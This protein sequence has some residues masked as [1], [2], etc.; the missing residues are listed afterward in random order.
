MAFMGRNIG[1]GRARLA[2]AGIIAIFGRMS[3][4]PQTRRFPGRRRVPRP[5]L[6]A[7]AIALVLL[8]YIAPAV[9]RRLTDLMWYEEVGLGHV[10]W[11]KI[12]AQWTLGLSIGVV[13]LLLFVVN[14]RWALVTWV[15]GMVS[16]D[17]SDPAHAVQAF[18]GA[19]IAPL[20]RWIVPLVLAA[21][22]GFGAATEWMTV[23]QFWY[24]TPFGVTD[25]IFQRDIGYYV[26]TVPMI[27]A[28]LT[29]LRA[30]AILSLVVIA[31]PL[32]LGLG[33]VGWVYRSRRITPRASRHLAALVATVLVLSGLSTLFVSVPDALQASHAV[34]QGATYTDIHIRIPMLRLLGIVTLVGALWVIYDAWRGRFVRGA[35]WVLGAWLTMTVV[36]IGVVPLTYQR[37]VVQANEL[38]RE[39]P[40]LSHYIA[41]TRRAWGI[42]S[43]DHRELRPPVAPLTW[44]DIQANRST[45][46]NI[47]L[48]DQAELLETY[49]QLQSIRTYYDFVGIDDDRY[50]IAGQPRQLLLSVRELNANALP[51]R[52][53]INDHLTYTHG[54]GLTLSPANAVTAEGLPELW[55]QDL[56]PRTNTSIQ[57]SRPQVYFGELTSDFAIAPSRQHEFDYPAGSG[58]SA[59]YSQ[60]AGKAG[61][62]ARSIVTRLLFALRFGSINILL[63]DDFTP[64]TRL[65]INRD[66]RRRS[67]LALPFLRFDGDPY[68]VVAADGTLKWILDAYTTTTRY[69][70]SQ[71]ARDGTNYMRNSVKVVID[72]Y[73]GTITPYIADPGDPMIRTL[74]RIYPNVLRPIDEMP[75]DL[76]AHVRY[77]YDLFRMQ[78]AMYA[79]FHMTDPATFYHREDQWQVPVADPGDTDSALRGELMRHMVMRLPGEPQSEFVLMRPFTPRQKD[80]LSAWMVARNDGANYGRLVVYAFPRQS[81]VFGPRQVT[82]RINQDTE[83]SREVSL[84]DQRGSRVIHGE[85]LV[86]PV[87]NSLI[88]VDPLYLRA[89][90][91]RIPE[92]KRVVVVHENQVAMAENLELALRR[93]FTGALA[94]P[95]VAVSDS[96]ARPVSTDLGTLAREAQDHFDRAR[97]AQRAD[98]WATYGDEMKKLA[99]VLRRMRRP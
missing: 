35:A 92:L 3:V 49:G 89:P 9:A 96:G 91:G 74:A 82:N 88:Y 73:D 72:A 12:A 60:Y 37:L 44:Q 40:Q 31:L 70:Y 75:A 7:L 48:W 95:V 24:R 23:I 33:E 55:V 62:S 98:D 94:A 68:N 25:P 61:I 17:R 21:I 57:I 47:R 18:F 50:D 97:A 16:L 26:Y 83:V 77:P 78:T 4:P 59:V 69:P 8:F 76:R 65:L 56:P 71:R 6:I 39:T 36:L 14:A 30:S 58:D 13:S 52:S 45:I 10:F 80:N 29:W 54:M 34:L 64:D 1:R 20:F 42:D 99:D 11:L 66:I 79:L 63:S 81:L 19:V 90:G 5:G 41:M 85:L 32:Y 2:P 86:I 51:I 53:F 38:A 15:P 43:V 93:L 22:I 87:G 84:W 46:D 67:Q 27:E 28:V